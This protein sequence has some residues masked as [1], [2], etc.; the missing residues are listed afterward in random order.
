MW[1]KEYRKC[2]LFPRD[3]K[4]NLYYMGISEADMNKHTCPNTVKQALKCTS[5]VLPTI[6]DHCKDIHFDIDLLFVNKV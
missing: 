4:F 1:S 3:H 2:I 5:I 6:M